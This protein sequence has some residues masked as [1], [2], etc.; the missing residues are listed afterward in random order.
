MQGYVSIRLK[1]PPLVILNA[2]LVQ[3]LL[4]FVSPVGAVVVL[5]LG[6]DIL[7]NS[8]YTSVIHREGAIACLP[9]EA[10]IILFIQGLDPLAAVC[11]DSLHEVG[12]GDGLGQGSEDVDMVAYT[13]DF[14]GYTIHVADD[15]ADVGEHL[16]EVFVAYLH[17]MIFDVEDDMDVVFASELPMVVE[18]LLAGGLKSP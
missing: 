6:A 9:T 16:P 14:Y 7:R 18:F 2:S 1:R 15:T 17:A 13:T 11:L 8:V 12:Q 4:V 3:E 10:F 5:R